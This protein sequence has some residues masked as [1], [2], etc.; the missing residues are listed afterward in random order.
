MLKDR[1]STLLMGSTLIARHTLECLSMSL[2]LDGG[3]VSVR[4]LDISHPLPITSAA[5]EEPVVPLCVTATAERTSDTVIYCEDLQSHY[6]AVMKR[7][8]KGNRVG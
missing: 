8:G 4:G 1:F 2:V 7:S 3:V 6:H 5:Y